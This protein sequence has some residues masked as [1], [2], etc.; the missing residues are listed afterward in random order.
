MVLVSESVFVF[1]IVEVV[2]EVVQGLIHGTLA[3]HTRVVQT[4]QR[5]NHTNHHQNLKAVSD[6]SSSDSDRCK[7]PEE[8]DPTVRLFTHCSSSCWVLT[9]LSLLRFSQ[10]T[11]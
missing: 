9:L 6:D 11:S 4:H 7:R 3:A 1:V 8:D 2:A 5:T 10:E